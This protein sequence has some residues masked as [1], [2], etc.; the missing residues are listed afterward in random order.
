V[1]PSTHLHDCQ[2]QQ[3]T[4]AVDV[5]NAKFS[6]PDFVS[7]RIVRVEEEEEVVV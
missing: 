7:S 6:F 4:S 5:H 2:K 1:K 3:R